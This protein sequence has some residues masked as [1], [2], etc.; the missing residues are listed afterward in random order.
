MSEKANVVTE[1]MTAADLLKLGFD[2]DRLLLEDVS[3][4]TLCSYTCNGNTAAT[5]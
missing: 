4:C 2:D 5:Q 3:L 1:A